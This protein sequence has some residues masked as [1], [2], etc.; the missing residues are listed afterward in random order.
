MLVQATVTKNRMHQRIEDGIRQYLPVGTT[1][2]WC[3]A[4][5]SNPLDFCVAFEFPRKIN[6][7]GAACYN[8]TEAQSAWGDGDLGGYNWTPYLHALVEQVLGYPPGSES[9]LRFRK[10]EAIEQLAELTDQLD[11]IQ[12]MQRYWLSKLRLVD[13]E[14]YPK[15]AS[16]NAVVSAER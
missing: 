7:Q 5:N 15:P 14:R 16:E 9:D 11:Q 1:F 10:Q 6:G 2:L 12:R 13:S 8:L 3:A 4:Q